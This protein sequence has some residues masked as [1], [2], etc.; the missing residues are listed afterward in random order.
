MDLG[1]FERFVIYQTFLVRNMGAIAE[2]ARKKG[3]SLNELSVLI[4]L[5][6]HD[7]AK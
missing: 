3:S 6:Y 5:R 2:Y 1:T 7:S 4:P